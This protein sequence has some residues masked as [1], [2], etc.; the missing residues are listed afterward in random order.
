M[1][2]PVYPSK[3]GVLP[4]HTVQLPAVLL[5]GEVARELRVSRSTVYR[6]CETGELRCFRVANAIRVARDALKAYQ[7]SRG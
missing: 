7:V 4:L 2:P 5:V 6:V 1:S 3:W